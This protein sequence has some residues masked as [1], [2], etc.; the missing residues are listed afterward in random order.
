MGGGC[1]GTRSSLVLT[2][3]SRFHTLTSHAGVAELVDAADSKSNI[4]ENQ[5]LATDKES[6]ED[7][8]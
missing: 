5:D 7:D 3:A 6:K 2:D 1:G 4:E 8:E